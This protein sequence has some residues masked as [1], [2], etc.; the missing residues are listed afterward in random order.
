MTQ[1]FSGA[2]ACG[3]G[4]R[5]R[6]AREKRGLTL[7]GAAEKLHVD[8]RLLEALEAED[9]AALGADVYVRGHLRRYAELLGESPAEFQEL[10]IHSSQTQGPD[11][12]HIMRSEHPRER[13]RLIVPA[14]LVL[15]GFALAGLLSWMLGEKNRRVSVAPPIPVHE[16][17]VAPVTPTTPPQLATNL[18]S[19]PS[20]PLTV[21]PALAHETQLTLQL[22]GES[23]VEISDVDGRQLL[24]GLIEAGSARRASGAPPLRLVLGNAPAVALQ[25]NGQ[26]VTLAGLVRRDGSAHVLIDDTGR[27]SPAPPR[28]AHGD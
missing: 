23:W 13:S 26:A 28:L 5:L 16:A 14:I 9:F 4:P 25:I 1:Q 15:V 6:G 8:A 19:T 17:P 27:V 18:A 21:T 20:A 24:Q 3:I 7:L 10:Y 2:P 11:L 12:T 22:A